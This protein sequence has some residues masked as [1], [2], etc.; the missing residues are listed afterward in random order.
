ME[1]DRIK[2]YYKVNREDPKKRFGISR[3]EDIYQKR[4]GAVDEPHRHDFF[5]VILVQ[6]AK[7]THNI[8]FKSYPLKGSEV[9]FISPGQVHQIIEEEK[10]LGYSIVFSTDFL[11]E[12]NIPRDFI[13]DLNL[14]QDYGISP[15]LKLNQEQFNRLASY[16]RTMELEIEENHSF[17]NQSLGAWLKLFLI[18]CNNACQQPIEKHSEQGNY[19]LKSFKALVDQHYKTEHTASF[20]A[21][22]LNISSDHLNRVVKS[23]IGKTAKDYIQSR[24]SIAAK[25][26]LYFSGLSNKEIAFELGFLEPAHFSAFF[27][28][29]TGQS[30]TQF[31]KNR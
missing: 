7:G 29:C 18:A 8:D 14:F 27:K 1:L 5:T 3:M 10:S 28:K 6:H 23:L 30:P 16:C 11:I 9:F 20:Y 24:I 19:L 25:R 13:D 12:N 21:K 26:M 15:S 17:K 4:K 2:T 22:Q 31:Q